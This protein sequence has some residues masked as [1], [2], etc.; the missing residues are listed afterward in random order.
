[1]VEPEGASV[2]DVRG[3]GSVAAICCLWSCKPH[4]LP[5]HAPPPPRPAAQ[6]H[7]RLQWRTDMVR[8]KST[9]VEVNLAG[10]SLVV[11]GGLQVRWGGPVGDGAAPQ[12]AVV[13]FLAT[14]AWGCGGL[15]LCPPVA[16][17]WWGATG[18]AHGQACAPCR[19]S[20]STSPPT[21]S[22]PPPSGPSWTCT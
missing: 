9:K 1:M 14:A 19:T 3:E 16:S 12:P 22:A 21:R 18:K 4:P 8:G 17:A 6:V 13:V 2:G 5:L 10:L 15:L 11:M 7:L 20:C